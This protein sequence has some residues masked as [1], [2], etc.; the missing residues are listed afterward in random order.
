[1]IK[2][3]FFTSKLDFKSGWGTL[4][5]NYI[6]EFKKK[7]VIVF[8]NKKNS[9]F[10]CE[11][12]EILRKPLDYIKNP[13]LIFID[14]F[15]IKKILTKYDNCKIYSHFPVEPYC[16]FLPLISNFFY[17][18]IYYAIGT[19]SLELYQ[20]Y[21]TKFLFNLAKKN[22][23]SIIF[24]SSFTRNNI[25]KKIKFDYTKFKETINPTIILKKIKRQK[26]FKKKTIVCVGEIK[27][28]NQITV[29]IKTN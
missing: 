4:T 26:K 15:K 11:Q 18:N 19:Y 16:L 23:Q 10:N 20:N 8:C 24:F 5:I 13:F 21:R 12:Y 28:R 9:A 7:D 25:E 3:L 2:Q 17:S 6:N 1:M 22:F 14:Y 27:P 29:I